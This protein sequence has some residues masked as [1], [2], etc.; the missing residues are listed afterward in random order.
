MLDKLEIFDMN[1]MVGR[2]TVFNNNSFYKITDLIKHM[3]YYGIHKALVYHATAKEYDPEY[4]NMYLNKEI[5][6]SSD[7]IKNRL[8]KCYVIYPRFSKAIPSPED[9]LLRIKNQNFRSIRIFPNF[10]FFSLKRRNFSDYFSVFE[11]NKIPVLVDYGNT[12]PFNDNINWED[13]YNICYDY[14]KIPFVLIRP[15]FRTSK[16]LYL[17]LKNTEN[18]YIEFSGYWNYRAIE[19]ICEEFGADRLIFG[20]NLPHDNPGCSLGLLKFAN[21]D[22]T[23]IKKIAFGN[24]NALLGL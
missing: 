7:I 10:H 3:D 15:G 14:P 12:F 6:E 9:V 2:Y 17:L 24:L 4:G 19:S 13:V 8:V 16:E 5:N 23:K 18:L 20:S 21:I 22:I 1:V 11:K